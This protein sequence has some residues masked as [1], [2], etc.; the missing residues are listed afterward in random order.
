MTTFASPTVGLERNSNAVD[1]KHTKK[2][3]A[4]TIMSTSVKESTSNNDLF[5]EISAY[6]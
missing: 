2:E 1:N 3:A 5:E 6:D 4:A